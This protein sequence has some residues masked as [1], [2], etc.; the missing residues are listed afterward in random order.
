MNYR[1]SCKA[2]QPGLLGASPV[3]QGYGSTFCT[4][5][6]FSAWRWKTPSLTK[7]ALQMLLTVEAVQAIPMAR[8]TSGKGRKCC[9]ALQGAVCLLKYSSALLATVF[10]PPGPHSWSCLRHPGSL[11]HALL[12][13]LRKKKTYTFPK[14]FAVRPNTCKNIFCQ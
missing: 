11:Q 9:K 1:F 10:L 14:E 2:K 6:V 13:M 4:S 7:S 12:Q 5:V 8:S 3:L